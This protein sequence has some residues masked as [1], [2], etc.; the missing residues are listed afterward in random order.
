MSSRSILVTG[1]LGQVGLELSQLDWGEGISLLLPSRQELDIRDRSSIRRF[2]EGRSISAIINCAAYTAVDRAEAE[3]ELCYATNAFGPCW[4]AT[5]ARDLNLP[6]LHVSTDY[7]FGRGSVG[8]RSEDD[9]VGPTSV[10]GASKLAGEIAVQA[11]TDRAVIL[12]TA[13]VVSRHRSNFLKTMLELA[14]Q[15]PEIRVVDD[16]RG[17]PTAAEDIARMLQSATTRLLSDP[18]APTGVF[19][20][21]NQGEASWAELA[22]A[23]M[24]EAKQV[25]LPYAKIVPVTTAEFPTKVRR[26]EDSRLAT[27]RLARLYHVQPRPWRE[28]INQIV[29]ELGTVREA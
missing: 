12:R 29:R 27:D 17:C 2:L 4:L 6:M 23:I 24:E 21:V 28:A 20:F 16:Q 9:P 8:F 22:A 3:A 7:V 10:Y 11:A 26:P 5:E 1:G 14:S 15:Q 25:G 13:W 19:H 18:D